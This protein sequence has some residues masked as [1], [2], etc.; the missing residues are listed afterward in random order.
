MA[1]IINRNVFADT[2]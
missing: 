2:K 1:V